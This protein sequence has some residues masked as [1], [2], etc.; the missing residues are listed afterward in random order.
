MAARRSIYRKYLA[1][2]IALVAGA[3]VVSGAIGVYFSYLET[4]HSLF[5]LAHEKAASAATRIEQ[6][7]KEIENQVA[8][9]TL[10]P[11]T[12]EGADP[13]E[14][15]RFDF[16]RLG[17]LV[18][19]I[20]EANYIDADGCLQVKESRLRSRAPAHASP[21]CRRMRASSARERAASITARSTSARKPSPTWRSR[22]APAAAA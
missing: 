1:L 4:R 22:C 10:L 21:T 20:T 12:A 18:Q 9:T 5:S 11:Q 19:P 8:W 13:L 2:I 17:K 15:R 7:V 16:V 3:L 14:P 6:F